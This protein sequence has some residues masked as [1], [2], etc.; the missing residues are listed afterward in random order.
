MVNDGVELQGFKEAIDP[1]MAETA[2]EIAAD[3]MT[4][5][6]SDT[7]AGEL[8]SRHTVGGLDGEIRFADTMGFAG[9]VFTTGEV[10]RIDRPY[11]DFRFNRDVDTAT[12]YQTESLLCVPVEEIDGRIIGVLQAMNSAR[13]TFNADDQVYLE[14]LAM[15]IAKAI[16]QAG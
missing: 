16:V 10:V 7:S 6:L 8:F 5:L 13:G 14:N 1:L 9:H 11:E 15:Q 2:L 3:R 4:L 12:G